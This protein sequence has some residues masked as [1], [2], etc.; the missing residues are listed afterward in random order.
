MIQ[1]YPITYF[2]DWCVCFEYGYRCTRFR[3][4]LFHKDAGDD[5][6]VGIKS[7]A[8]LFLASKDTEELMRLP[9]RERWDVLFLAIVEIPLACQ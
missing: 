8:L 1:T 7:T 4:W 5:L 9:I 3:L 6:K 2:L